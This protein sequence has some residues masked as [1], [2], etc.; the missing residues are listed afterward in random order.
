M[1][2]AY[3]NF[4]NN[5]IIFKFNYYLVIIYFQNKV[6]FIINTKPK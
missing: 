2:K 6:F 5:I 3:T 1:R 4:F